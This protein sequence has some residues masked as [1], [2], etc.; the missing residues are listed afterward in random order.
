MHFYFKIKIIF[1]YNK[2]KIVLMKTVF[3]R[4]KEQ[5]I[6]P[7]MT[8]KFDDLYNRDERFFAVLLKGLIAWLNQNI[9]LYNKPINHFIFN[10]G[11]SYMYVE[12]NGYEFKWSETT[13]EDQMYMH[14]PR[15]VIEMQGI[16]IPT[17]ELSQP[18]CRSTYERRDGKDI[19]AFNAEIRRMPVELNVELKYT[20][21]NFNE[22]IVLL[23][24]LLDKIVFQKYFNITYLGKV[25]E[26]SIELPLDYTTEI[27]KIDMTSPEINQK[28]IT[29]SVKICSNYPIVNTR[30]EIRANKII[31]NFAD[32][33]NLHD[34]DPNLVES[35]LIDK[36][37]YKYE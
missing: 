20:L 25:I 15:C 4:E 26:C 16:N 37:I 35:D 19:K 21:A 29:L 30:S 24:E 31:H 3:N 18:H 13:G 36:E 23:Q 10:T 28:N 17:E 8:D 32:S 33:V 12:K 6:R 34:D 14:L 11:S 2:D 5:W 7:W 1:I 22:T 9:I 27:N